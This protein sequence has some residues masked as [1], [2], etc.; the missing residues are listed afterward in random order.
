MATAIVGIGF[1]GV[2]T[3]A[4]MSEL[5]LHRSVA[6]Q[7]MQMQADQILATIEGDTDNIDQYTLT[8]TNCSAPEQTDTYLV[9]QYEWCRRLNA[10]VG[11]AT[12]SD[13]R[14]ITVTTLVDG[15][16]VVSILLGSDS[17]NVQ[18]VMKRVYLPM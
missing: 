18:V 17:G 5:T 7:K 4:V 9:R 2:Y 15:R 14:T 16:K 10:E 6:K 3:L 13:T 8:L 11:T 12:N 1:V